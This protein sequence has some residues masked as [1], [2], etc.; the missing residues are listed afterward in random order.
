MYDYVIK[1][2]TSQKEAIKRLAI[3]RL[4]NTKTNTLT[5]YPNDVTESELSSHA[6][7]YCDIS[8][9][10][11]KFKQLKMLLKASEKRRQLKR[12]VNVY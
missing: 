11:I 2:K 5:R 3:K 7:L 12:R 4:I 1:L 10:E 6:L 8:L 9:D